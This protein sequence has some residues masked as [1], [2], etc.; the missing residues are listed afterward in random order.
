MVL[1]RVMGDGH[2]ASTL[3]ET[4][5]PPP[6]AFG[7]FLSWCLND[8]RQRDG[9]AT[10]PLAER[11]VR[12]DDIIC[13]WLAAWSRRNGENSAF[14]KSISDPSVQRLGKGVGDAGGNKIG[15]GHHHGKRDIR[16]RAA[17]ERQDVRQQRLD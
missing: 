16:H 5:K 13:I 8:R 6:A 17:R 4:A 10:H 7:K 15:G 3:G 2:P 11:S 14:C 1:A 9:G 12:G